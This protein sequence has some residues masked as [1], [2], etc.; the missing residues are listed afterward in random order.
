MKNKK[1]QTVGIVLKSNRKILE[2]GKT[3]IYMTA[4]F[5]GLVQALG[6]WWLN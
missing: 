3:Y 1:Y 4:Y 6:D 2:I 5:P